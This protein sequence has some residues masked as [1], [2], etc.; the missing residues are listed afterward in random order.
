M[1]ASGNQPVGRRASSLPPVPDHPDSRRTTPWI[2]DPIT[3][4]NRLI[5]VRHHQPG[6]A[7]VLC[8]HGLSRNI[9]LPILA[10]LRLASL[11]LTR[12]AGPKN[13]PVEYT[14]DP[15]IPPPIFSQAHIRLTLPYFAC[16]A[17]KYSKAPN[18]WPTKQKLIQKMEFPMALPAGPCF[19]SIGAVIAIS[20][21]WNSIPTSATPN[22]RLARHKST[23]E[24]HRQELIPM[25][26]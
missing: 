23:C 8:F 26:L 4:N 24:K 21:N 11:R 22:G 16:H 2:P 17:K 14:L 7:Y 5:V 3:G 19:F 9:R 18:G 1:A 6:D 10:K 12:K 20:G 13:M 15:L 25:R